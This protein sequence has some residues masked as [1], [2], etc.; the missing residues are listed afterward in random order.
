MPKRLTPQ[1]RSR[2]R[3]VR[4][5]L[6]D[7][8]G[9]L[10]D[11]SVWMGDGVETKRFNIRDGLGLKILQQYGIRVGWVSRRPS[12]ATRARARDLKIDFLMQKDAGKL[13]AVE[14]VLSRTGLTWPE[15]C[16]VGDDIVDTGVMRRAGVGVA[17]ADA[18]PEARA[19]ADFVTLARGGRGAV[20]EVVEAIL[21]AQGKW[22]RVVT[23]YAG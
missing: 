11:G 16:F 20:R 9:V 8:D 15:L 10:T 4:L 1:L 13:D 3:R 12:S 5:F 22:S 21:T 18:V 17:V 19:A 7:V 2:L 14:S 6:C 23:D